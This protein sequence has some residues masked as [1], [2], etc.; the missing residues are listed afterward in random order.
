MIYFK[1]YKFTELTIQQ[2]YTILALRSDV[3]VVEQRCIYL[4][5]D[6]KDFDAMHLLGMEEEQLSAYIRLFPPKED[7]DHIV[8][9]RVVTSRAVRQRG[10][11][12]K[13]MQEMLNYC[14][15]H[16]PGVPIK[17][18]AQHYLQKFY[19]GF[20]LV[21][22]GDVYQEDGLPHIAMQRI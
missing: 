5:A 7:Q 8:F 19:E 22:Y 10:Y 13:L 6:G 4:D 3:F 12:K 17:C 2:L 15:Q 16:F 20:G 14:D 21:T 9:G 18:S 11:G 1:W